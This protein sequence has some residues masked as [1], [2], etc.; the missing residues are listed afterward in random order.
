VVDNGGKGGG[1][2]AKRQMD[3]QTMTG[4]AYGENDSWINRHTDMQPNRH[5]DGQMS[6][7]T[8]E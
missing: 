7:D 4:E 6:R 2:S 1:R 3:R 8:E 5:A